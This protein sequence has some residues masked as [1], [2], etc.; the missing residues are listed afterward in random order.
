MTDKEDSKETI[1][2]LKQILASVKALDH[3]GRGHAAVQSRTEK[4]G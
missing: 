3:Y 1:E 4:E 2:L